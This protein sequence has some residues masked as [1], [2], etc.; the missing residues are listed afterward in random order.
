[1]NT[2]GKPDNVYVTEA[3]TMYREY[4]ISLIYIYD[5]LTLVCSGH[6]FPIVSDRDQFIDWLEYNDNEYNSNVDVYV[7]SDTYIKAKLD[8]V[9][10]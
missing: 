2:L 3:T 5:E 1:M 9:E 7:Y 6:S 8:K 10:L 4:N